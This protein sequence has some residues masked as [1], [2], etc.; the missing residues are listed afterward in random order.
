M[1]NHAGPR[2]VRIPAS[3]T[4][5]KIKRNRSN[6]W[7]DRC[8]QLLWHYSRTC[9][10]VV[11]SKCPNSLFSYS[12]RKARNAEKYERTM[13]KPWEDINRTTRPSLNKNGCEPKWNYLVF[14]KR[15]RTRNKTFHCGTKHC[16][17][18]LQ[19]F[20]L[21]YSPPNFLSRYTD[22]SLCKI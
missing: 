2:S 21:W 10:R 7:S 20:L 8:L 17:R 4:C 14:W 13:Q 19:K 6:G 11:N 3:K 1:T 5:D 16:L 15:K 12:M 9:P 18:N 22:R